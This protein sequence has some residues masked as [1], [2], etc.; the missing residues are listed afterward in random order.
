MFTLLAALLLLGSDPPPVETIM[1]RVAENQTRAQEARKQW[2]YQQS[3]LVRLHRS[4]G[5]LAREEQHEYLVAPT[6][7]GSEKT[8]QHVAGKYERGGKYHEFTEAGYK[9]KDLDIDG[10]LA[11]DLAKDLGHSEASRD[12]VG[13]DF[14]PLTTKEQAKY[15]FTLA[16]K[17]SYRG[18]DV[19][20]VTFRPKPGGEEDSIWK[21]EALIDPQEF[22][23]VMITT[24]LAFHIPFAVRTLLGTNLEHLGFKITYKK[25]ADEVWFPAT[26][27]GEFYLRGVFFY[28]RNISI[29]V[30]NSEFRKADVTSKIQFE[31]TDK[32]R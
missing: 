27:G 2:I 18:Q 20:K 14:F 5:K 9:Y 1:A 3:V 6:A 19:Y 16:G 28:K 29:S 10:D 13:A 30:N 24:A 15:V 21:G 31:T 7:S 32:H 12:G 17:E 22:Q 25:L 23:P 11:G 26:Y 4:N 8:L